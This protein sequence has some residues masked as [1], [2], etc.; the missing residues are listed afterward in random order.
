MGPRASRTASH[1]AKAAARVGGT[2]LA[3]IL[4]H[5]NWPFHTSLLEGINDKIKVIKRMGD[6]ILDNPTWDSYIKGVGGND[7]HPV[8]AIF[9]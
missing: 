7:E 4:A 2:D 1:R 8:P 3:G 6:M 5:A 9:P